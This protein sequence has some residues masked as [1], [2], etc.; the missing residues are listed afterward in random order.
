MVTLS[1]L[2]K[3]AHVSV[4][5]V[6]KAFSMSP[7]VNEQTREQI[8]ELARELGC[9]KKYYKAQYPRLMIAVICPEFK[10]RLYS[11]SLSVLQEYLSRHNCEICAA[12]T[13]FSGETEQELLRYYNRHTSVDGIIVIGPCG[14]PTPELEQELE[15][16]VAYVLGKNPGIFRVNM[17]TQ[18]AIEQAVD[19]FLSRGVTDIALLGEP[20]TKIKLQTF[21]NMLNDRGYPVPENRIAVS[22]KRFEA[23][24][25]EA[26]AQLLAG[27]KPP[28]AV[29]CGY[30]YMA[31]G[32]IRC[33]YD[34]GLSVPEDIAVLGMDDL[35]EA[36][37]LNPPLSSIDYP[38]DRCCALAA[39]ALL[40]QLM[41]RPHS[42]Q[43]VVEAALHLRR[44]TEI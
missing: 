24:G 7:E 5:T 28:R 33:I 43:E 40:A 8:F 2:A 37:Y 36:K 12:A 44:S 14:K 39:D 18:P 11:Q 23:G 27:G 29:I 13:D 30:D 38:I 9:F 15:L 4:S 17:N 21:Q 31:I 35:Y 22:E 25:Y 32:A 41:G 20:R 1:K 3:L 42:H 34:R 6:S 16:P 19:H 10:S 26:M